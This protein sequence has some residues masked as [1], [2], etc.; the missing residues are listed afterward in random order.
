MNVTNLTFD[1]LSPKTKGYCVLAGHRKTAPLTKTQQFII[2][3]CFLSKK[4]KEILRNSLASYK[5]IT[6]RFQIIACNRFFD[7]GS[8]IIL[9]V[10][11]NCEAV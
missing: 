7:T 6:I 11:I 8:K 4:K 9:Q 3:I 1:G 10:S 5:D 2:I